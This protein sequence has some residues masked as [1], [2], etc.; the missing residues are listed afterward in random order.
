MSAEYPDAVQA[1]TWMVRG[2]WV[3][4]CLRAA[5]ELNLIDHLDQ[6]LTAESLAELTATDPSTLARLL[7]TLEDLDIVAVG[8]DD[9]YAPTALGQTLR[10]GH[11]SAMRDLV[12]MQT[13]LAN[14]ASWHELAAAIRSGAGVFET[15]NGVS[16]WEYLSADPHRQAVFDA[17]MARRGVAQA[18]AI[19]SGCDLT[20]V[21]TVVDVGGGQG[22]ML[23]SLLAAEPQLSGVVADRPEVAAAAR[24]AFAAAGLVGRADGVPADF[25]EAVPA[26]GDAYV[27]SNILHDWPDHESVSILRTVRAT[28][29][30]GAR[31]WI[32]ELVLDAPG[33]PFL[34][35]RDLHLVDLHML[36]MFGSRERTA[37]EYGD[38]LRAAGFDRGTL[39]STESNW[40]VIEAWPA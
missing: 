37:S 32:V 23:I 30:P 22:G 1:V 5:A 20:G 40:D 15:V 14:L 18:A 38:L 31:L 9:R 4:L 2:H 19:R 7:R 33:R 24:K 26:T 39:L 10:A 36:V 6:P 3:A 11:P 16:N 25:F 29:K 34:K 35:R 17:A 8:A 12:L 21:S 28:M 13:E 27:L